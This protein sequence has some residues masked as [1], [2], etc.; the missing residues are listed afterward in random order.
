MPTEGIRTKYLKNSNENN[1]KIVI[2]AVLLALILCLWECW[3]FAVVVLE[4]CF[5]S[6]EASVKGRLNL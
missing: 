5:D 3:H 6:S 1:I 4:D 2:S